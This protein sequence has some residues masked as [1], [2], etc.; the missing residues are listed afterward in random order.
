MLAE[1]MLR[2]H[3]VL[4]VRSK[5]S[6]AV[7]TSVL[8]DLLKSKEERDKVIPNVDESICEKITFALEHLKK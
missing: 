8:L 5:H 6:R 1:V 7:S 4:F 3:S 2:S